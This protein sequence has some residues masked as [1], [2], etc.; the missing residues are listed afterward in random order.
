MLWR[1][2]FPPL[3]L[4]NEYAALSALRL[5]DER[6]LLVRNFSLV[7]KVFFRTIGRI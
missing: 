7:S 2:W 6:P 1:K 4:R 5:A 3:R